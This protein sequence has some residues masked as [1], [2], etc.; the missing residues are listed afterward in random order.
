[1]CTLAR[2]VERKRADK[3]IKCIKILQIMEDREGNPVYSTPYMY[4]HI[5]EE[6]LKGEKPLTP[7]KPDEEE[8]SESRV[9]SN[10]LIEGGFIHV[11]THNTS[12]ATINADLEY[13]CSDV[14]HWDS[15]LSCSNNFEKA[16]NLP[17]VDPYAKVLGIAVFA[18]YIP[19]GTEYIRGMDEGSYTEV[20]V[21][22]EVYLTKC[23]A[24]F[25]TEHVYTDL[26]CVKLDK[27]M[28]KLYKEVS[29]DKD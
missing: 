12:Q 28:K 9:S 4:K 27:F 24:K 20:I 19:E 2:K 1:M 6:V 25:D 21:A 17:N 22:K 16:E 15:Y 3:K 11:F 8:I 23:V 14:G 26:G 18:G 10:Y 13:L 7:D 29:P 5:P